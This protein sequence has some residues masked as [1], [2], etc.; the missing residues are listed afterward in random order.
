M[1]SPKRLLDSDRQQIIRLVRMWRENADI[2]IKDVIAR[3]QTH[4]REKIERA[5]FENLF[6]RADRTP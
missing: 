5:P 3:M 1:P 2:P 4:G 6:L